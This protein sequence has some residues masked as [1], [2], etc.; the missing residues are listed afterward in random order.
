MEFKS[1]AKHK[2]PV[3]HGDIFILKDNQ[4]GIEI[5]K[6]HYCG[7]NWYLS[8]RSLG[9]YQMS[10]GT[11]DFR[12]AVSKAKKIIFITANNIVKE[13]NRFCL[14]EDVKVVRYQDRRTRNEKLYNNSPQ[15][16]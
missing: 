3:E 6:I 13:A 8:C 2:E 14:D 11:E 10:L 7:D 5:H 15:G 12:I 1:N 16:T 9:I 4:L